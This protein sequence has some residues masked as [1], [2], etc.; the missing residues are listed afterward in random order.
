M[1]I[2]LIHGNGIKTIN[3]VHKKLHKIFHNP[4][5]KEACPRY[6]KIG[7]MLY[8]QSSE[9]PKDKSDVLNVSEVKVPTG[10]VTIEMTI[11]AVTRK[12]G[13]NHS[14]MP[15][16]Y[17]TRLDPKFRAYMKSLGIEVL[18]ASYKYDGM[19]CDEE[20]RSRLATCCIVAECECD[21]SAVL[22]QFAVTG[23]GRAKYLGLGLPIIK[24]NANADM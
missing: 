6:C 13:R 1:F 21:D 11:A 10:K 9:P 2:S 8:V 5:D 24:A 19:V 17:R 22:E 4:T 7:T 20:H 15:N 16:E 23:Y 18:D 14:I 3:D 12:E